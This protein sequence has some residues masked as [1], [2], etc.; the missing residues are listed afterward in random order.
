MSDI[1]DI[2][3]LLKTMKILRSPG[4]CEW[5]AAQTH[6]SLKPYM[7]EEAFEAVEAIG[8]KDPQKL[9]EELGDVLLQ[10][11]FHAVIAEEKRE[12]DIYDVA[13]TLNEKLI[14]RHPHVFGNV[15]G[16]S[17][18]RWEEIKAS[19]KKERKK[20]LG[21]LNPALPGLSMARR[22]QEN[23]ATYGFD[24]KTP[25]PVFDKVEEEIQE[26]KEAKTEEEKTEEI[27]D[28]LFAVVNLARHLNIDPEVAVR[29]ANEKF[30]DR[31]EK[32]YELSEKEGV[33]FKSQPIE[34]MEKFWQKAKREE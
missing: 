21:N 17:Y 16:Y 22:I 2:E 26:L 23:A 32:M 28:L 7:V 10:V 27:G 33:D 25:E 5:D 24:W 6:E 11:I 34:I 15:K 12:F 13:K 9:K 19:E 8:S 18:E 31:F 20:K 3:E 1:K 14:R 4:G 30:I 29:K